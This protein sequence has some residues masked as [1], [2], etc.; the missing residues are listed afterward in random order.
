VCY[1][2]PEE[3]G[4]R[5]AAWANKLD[6]C[7]ARANVWLKRFGHEPSEAVEEALE[8]VKALVPCGGSEQFHP[9]ARCGEFF[10]D[11]PDPL[12]PRYPVEETHPIPGK[13]EC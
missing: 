3:V 13:A 6:W 8:R 4:N 9:C 5:I 10:F 12:A 11:C 2:E 7:L 1:I